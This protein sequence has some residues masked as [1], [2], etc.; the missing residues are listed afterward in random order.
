MVGKKIRKLR[1][2]AGLSQEALAEKMEV[3]RQAVSKWEN[4]LSVPDME[5]L[6]KLSAFLGFL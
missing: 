5:N 4:D 3:T 2:E 1:E 6:L